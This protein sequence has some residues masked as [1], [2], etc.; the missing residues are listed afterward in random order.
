MSNFRVSPVQPLRVSSKRSDVR[1][2]L[3]EGRWI[4]RFLEFQD[5]RIGFK[6]L[7]NE[8]GPIL[9]FRLFG[10]I[11]DGELSPQERCR[12][13]DQ[14][15]SVFHARPVRSARRNTHRRACG[16]NAGE[17]IHSWFALDLEV[18]RGLGVPKKPLIDEVLDLIHRAPFASTL[19]P[20]LFVAYCHGSSP[21]EETLPKRR[22]RPEPRSV[23]SFEYRSVYSLNEH[24]DHKG[25]HRAPRSHQP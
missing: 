1:R 25:A 21:G 19:R 14:V 7:A 8:R 17:Y 9:N 12:Q 24:D 20:T 15:L 13:A 11:D 18:R 3:K 4:S 23:A 10:E 6:V 16:A 2:P 5:S 22:R